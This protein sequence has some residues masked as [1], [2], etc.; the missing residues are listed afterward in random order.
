MKKILEAE[1]FTEHRR[2]TAVGK[3]TDQLPAKRCNISDLP[4]EFLEQISY[5]IYVEEDLVNWIKACKCSVANL[6]DLG[7][8]SE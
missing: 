1:N 4:Y 6:G 8:L 7:L 2:K 5:C 3:H